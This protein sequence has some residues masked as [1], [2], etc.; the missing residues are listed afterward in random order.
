MRNFRVLRKKILPLPAR[1][2]EIRTFEC[3]TRRDRIRNEDVRKICE[4]QDVIRW[5]RIRRPCKQDNRLAKVAKSGK[6]NTIEMAR[7]IWM[8]SKRLLRKLDI[9]FAGE[10]VHWMKYRIWF[11]KRKKKKKKKKK[12][13]PRYSRCSDDSFSIFTKWNHICRLEEKRP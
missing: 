5:A 12:I 13:F 10:Q 4:V 9:N 1:T 8:A 7:A 3:N 6:P 2:T 11:Y